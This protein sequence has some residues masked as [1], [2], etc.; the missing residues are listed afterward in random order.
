MLSEIIFSSYHRDQYV[1]I[2]LDNVRPGTENNFAKKDPASTTLIGSYDYGSV[3][4]Y[5]R[6]AFSNNG[7][8][9]ITPPSG[10]ST[11]GQRVGMSQ[12]DV[13]K[14]MGFYE[15][16]SVTPPPPPSPPPPPPP[17]TTC[18]TVGGS[19]PNKPCVFPF[20]FGGDVYNECIFEGNQPGETE[21]WCSTQTDSNGVHVGGQG[22]WGFCSSNCPEIGGPSPPPPTPPPPTPP[23][24]SICVTESG[25]DPNKP[26]IFPFEFGG[27]TYNE[28]TFEGNQPGDTQPWCS[29]LTNNNGVHVGG[30]GNWGFCSSTCQTVG[31]PPPPPPGPPPPPPSDG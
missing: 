20:Q 1:R 4:H 28:C 27:T 5:S 14:L 15:C 19:D 7:I 23:P 21:P 10:I 31:P 9:T 2:N 3:M 30:Q 17:G 26:C 16:S 12:Q 24:P 22:N 8:E 18:I 13:N 6:C 11:L 29:T 25:P